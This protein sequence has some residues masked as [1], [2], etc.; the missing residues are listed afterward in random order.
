VTPPLTI[1]AAQAT[2]L[3]E[4]TDDVLVPLPDKGRPTAAHLKVIALLRDPVETAEIRA[5]LNAGK[6]KVSGMTRADGRQAI[7]LIG[8]RGNPVREYDVASGTYIPIR[9]IVRNLG[10]LTIVTYGEYRV[11]PATPANQRLLNLAVRRPNARVD[12]NHA[13]YLAATKRLLN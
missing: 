4:G 11:L 5:Q 6:F 9:K 12:R 8:V 1:T 2:V 7:K 10:E 3:R 13:D